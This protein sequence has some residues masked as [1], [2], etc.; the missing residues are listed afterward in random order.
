MRNII[1]LFFT[2]LVSFNSCSTFSGGNTSAS[3]S[4]RSGEFITHIEIRSMAFNPRDLIIPINTTIYW[5]NLDNAIHTVTATSGQ[6]YDSG[7]LSQFSGFSVRYTNLGTNAYY[8]YYHPNMTGKVIVTNLSIMSSSGNISSSASVS[9]GQYYIEIKNFAFNPASLIIPVNTMV[10]WTNKE[11]YAHRVIGTGGQ[12]FDSGSLGQDN[13]Y[14][15]LFTNSGTNSYY[16][17]IHTSMIGKVI[18]TN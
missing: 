14:S 1:I 13:G 5:T 18:A 12:S 7:N 15:L 10:Y 16:C 17:S 4:S 2:A 6:N 3:I 9:P 8:C 11:S